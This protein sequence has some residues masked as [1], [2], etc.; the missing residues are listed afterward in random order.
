MPTELM[1]DLN[2]PN[3][4]TKLRDDANTFPYESMVSLVLRHYMRVV[5][6]LFRG[7]FFFVVKWRCGLSCLLIPI[8]KQNVKIKYI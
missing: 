1:L 5:N 8:G 3:S 2:Q 6:G 4:S 7:H